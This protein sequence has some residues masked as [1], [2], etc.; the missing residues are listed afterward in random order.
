M[1]CLWTSSTVTLY[2][3]QPALLPPQV[4][5][6]GTTITEEAVGHGT[7]HPAANFD[8]E[9]DAAA[10]KKAMKKLGEYNTSEGVSVWVEVWVCVRV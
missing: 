9:A 3:I 8:P 10:L 6:G 4:S 7:V 5:V 1:A 2:K